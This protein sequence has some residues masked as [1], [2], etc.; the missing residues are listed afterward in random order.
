VKLKDSSGTWREDNA[1]LKT[2]ISDYFFELFALQVEATDPIL[3]QR[4]K[5]RVTPEMNER[6]VAPFTEEEVKRCCLR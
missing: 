6:L 2:V 3:L 1:Q 4:V 5:P